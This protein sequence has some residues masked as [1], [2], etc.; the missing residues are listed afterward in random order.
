VSVALEALSLNTLLERHLPG[1]AK[2]VFL[3]ACRDNPL[4]RSLAATR[5]SARG[6]APINAA[7]GTLISYATRDG[8]TASDGTGRNSPYTTALLAHL[9]EAED[10]SL[11]LRRVRQRVIDSTRGAQE[12]WEYGSLVG[13]KLVLS[14][15]RSTR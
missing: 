10:I 1:K 11:V 12:P 14:Q 15:L 6:L 13:D 2:L 3:D 8:S 9:D 5:G 7:A 4:A